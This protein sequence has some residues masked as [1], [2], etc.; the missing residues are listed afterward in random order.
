MKLTL[1]TIVLGS[2]LATA[3][4]TQEVKVIPL[5]TISNPG[6]TY[7]GASPINPAVLSPNGKTVAFLYSSHLRVVDFATKVIRELRSDFAPSQS[8]VFSA[9][10]A[11]LRVNNLE[12]GDSYEIPLAGGPSTKAIHDASHDKVFVHPRGPGESVCGLTTWDRKNE[13]IVAVGVPGWWEWSRD[14]STLMMVIWEQGRHRLLMVDPQTGK[15]KELAAGAG[16]ID[17]AVWRPDE[18]LYFIKPG[19]PERRVVAGE[20]WRYPAAGGAAIQLTNGSGGF[21]KIVD[22]TG[23]G[24]LVAV[25]YRFGG[26]FWDGMLESAGL[27]KTSNEREAE[28]VVVRPEAK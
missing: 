12:T 23:D 22:R 13:R 16:R 14:G 24:L 2:L 18:G 21:S 8:F 5:G 7:R 15:S 28:L 25:R 27:G 11:S 9:D 26:D 6:T 19:K 4:Q 10:S 20:I 3:Q 1:P 17:S